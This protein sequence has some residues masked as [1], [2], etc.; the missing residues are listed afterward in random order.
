MGGGN[1]VTNIAKQKAAI[2]TWSDDP[3]EWKDKSTNHAPKDEHKY[4]LPKDEPSGLKWCEDVIDMQTKEGK[5]EK[6][7]IQVKPLHLFPNH[8]IS[9]D[10]LA[11][12]L[13]FDTRKCPISLIP[14]YITRQHWLKG[15]AIETLLHLS[16]KSD[17]LFNQNEKNRDIWAE[18]ETGISGCLLREWSKLSKKEQEKDTNTVIHEND[19]KKLIEVENENEGKIFEEGQPSLRYISGT[20]VC[21][22][23]AAFLT[24]IP[25]CNGSHRLAV[26]AIDPNNFV[27]WCGQ[28][29]IKNVSESNVVSDAG[30]I[31]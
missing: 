11:S 20:F 6:E 23:W 4:E 3:K 2:G 14:H 19:E 12:K 1:I 16:I 18:G 26:H 22:E 15:K 24:F 13:L 28:M 27:K 7:G 9:G 25:D 8:N 21:H 17:E 10:T 29:L 31:K 30:P 5:S